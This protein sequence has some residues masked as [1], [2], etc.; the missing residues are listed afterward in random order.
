[1]SSQAIFI[2]KCPVDGRS[3]GFGWGRLNSLKVRESGDECWKSQ[4]SVG[5]GGVNCKS[6]GFS[7]YKLMDGIRDQPGDVNTDLRHEAVNKM[8][9]G[10]G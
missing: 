1:M 9:L 3:D 6:G 7:Y 10:Y 2:N 8:A 5:F 4:G